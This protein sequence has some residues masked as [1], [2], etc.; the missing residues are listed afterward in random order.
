[1]LTWV[2]FLKFLD[3]LEKLQEEAVVLSGERFRP[4]VEAPYRWRDWAAPE[5]A[6]PATNSSPS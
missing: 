2:L 5:T 6:S 3:D 1:M 4:I